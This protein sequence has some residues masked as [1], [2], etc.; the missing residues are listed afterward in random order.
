M[1]PEEIAL[2]LRLMLEDAEAIIPINEN[3]RE[4][5]AETSFNDQQTARGISGAVQADGGTIS[6]SEGEEVRTCE[7]CRDDKYTAELARAPCQHEYCGSCLSHIFRNA[8]MDES[9]FPPRCCRETI[10]LDENLAFLDAD[11]VQEFGRKS[12][13]YST[14]RRTYCHN[15]Q[16]NAFIPPANYA[17][18][19]ATCTECGSKTCMTCKGAS[20]ED[21][22]PHD[23]EL[24][25]TLQMARDLHWQRCSSCGTYIEQNTG[26][27]HMTCRCGHEFCYLCGAVWKTCACE[28]WDEAHLY[29]GAPQIAAHGHHNNLNFDLH[30]LLLDLLARNPEPE[31]LQQPNHAVEEEEDEDEEENAEQLAPVEHDQEDDECLHPRWVDRRGAHN[32]EVC[33]DRMPLFIY[34]CLDCHIMVCRSCRR[35]RM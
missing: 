6:Q 22:C 18:D 3:E 25:Q 35:H 9:L 21:G 13:E 30:A 2:V 7:A 5:I 29:G 14:P 32:C 31:R 8:M 1:D 20:H 34:E 12:V 16:C 26:C 19:I 27:N 33:D 4:E 23:E 24:Q 28:Q 15:T 11:V 17:N 10:P